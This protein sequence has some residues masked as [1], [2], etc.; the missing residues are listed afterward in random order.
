VVTDEQVRLLRKKHMEGKT[1][2]AAAAAAGMSVRSARKWESGPLPSQTKQTRSWRTRQD[3]FEDVWDQEV[4]PLL[5][6][7]EGGKLEAKTVLEWLAE[8]YPDRYNEG[9]LRT[10]QRRFRDW[11]ALHGPAKEVFFEQEH[12]PGREASADFTDARE[13]GITIG[14]VEFPHLLFV[15]RFAFSGW[16]WATVAFSETF[17]ALVAGVQGA[18]W[19]MGGCPRQLRTDNLSAATHEIKITG[20]RTFNKRYTAVLDHYGIKP[21]RIAPSKSHE[22]GIV[23]KGHDLLKSRMEQALQLRGSRDFADETAYWTFIGE[24]MAYLNR[25][26]E[27]RLVEERQALLPL[28]SSAVPSYTTLRVRVRRWS[29]VRV[30]GRIYSVPSRLIG[31]E[32]EVRQHAD[33]LDVFYRGHLVE[34]LPRLRGQGGFR[35]DYRHVIW[36]LVRKPGAFAHYRYREELFPSPVFRAAYGVFKDARGDRADVEYVRVLHLAAST[37]EITVERALVTLLQTGASFGYAEVKDLA[38][39]E[40]SPV[41]EV[42]IGTPDLTKYD[43]LLEVSR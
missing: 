42:H 31:H 41:P 36:S 25:R 28:P 20:G 29:T 1:Q 5:T 2:E 11:R 8:R 24:Q 16:M 17:E 15:L 23:E 39:P 34:R 12:V 21:V 27:P 43:A 19:Q 26:C 18:L 40:S 3:P 32:V 13:L 38:A 30:G 10:L 14:G 4:V 7:D 33:A 9:Q 35:I 22:N 6:A 37:M